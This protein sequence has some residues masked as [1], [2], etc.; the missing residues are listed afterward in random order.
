MRRRRRRMAHSLV[1]ELHA[2][3]LL[4]PIREE[5]DYADFQRPHCI[6]QLLHQYS[7][8]HNRTWIAGANLVSPQDDTHIALFYQ[9]RERYESVSNS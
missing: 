5:D 1:G 3:M 7:L 6:D 2:N 9:D 8:H 4:R